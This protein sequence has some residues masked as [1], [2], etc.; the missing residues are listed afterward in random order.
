MNIQ[1]VK[2]QIGLG[3]KTLMFVRQMDQENKDTQTPWVSAWDNDTRIRVTM[4]E[5]ILAQLKNNPQF[6]GLAL[7][8]E[9]VA[10]HAD[11]AEYIRYV[12]ITPLNVEFTA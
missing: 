4:H 7:K 3:N 10:A 1:E 6:A 8:K 12:L 2:T 5:N 9:V 11:V